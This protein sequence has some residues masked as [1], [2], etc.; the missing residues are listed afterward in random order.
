MTNTMRKKDYDL[1]AGVIKADIDF[2]TQSKQQQRLEA[3]QSLRFWLAEEL[4]YANPCFNKKKFNKA[5]GLD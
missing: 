4:E 3:I 1:I 5:C 2:Y